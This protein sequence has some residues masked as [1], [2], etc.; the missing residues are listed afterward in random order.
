[1][2][3]SRRPKPLSQAK[4]PPSTNLILNAQKKSLPE[5]DGQRNDVAENV[6]M[7]NA[8]Q[9]HHPGPEGADRLPRPAPEGVPLLHVGDQAAENEG[10]NVVAPRV[11]IV[12]GVLVG[13]AVHRSVVHQRVHAGVVVHPGAVLEEVLN[14]VAV[15]PAD[16]A[17]KNGV[18]EKE[19][20]A[21]HQ[22]VIAS[23]AQQEIYGKNC[24]AGLGPSQLDPG[25]R[26]RLQ[27]TLQ[28]RGENVPR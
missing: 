10:V 14:D 7:N 9:G 3:R 24:A 4:H 25:H 12:T 20:T 13:V 28:R 18:R 26:R 1:M 8:D 23:Q 21:G 17:I 15:P 16:T 19:G 22:A 11:V 6:I 2:K 5:N 27:L